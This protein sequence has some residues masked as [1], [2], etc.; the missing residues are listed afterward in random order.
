MIHL[1]GDYIHQVEI[2]SFVTI[3]KDG[4]C[5]QGDEPARFPDLFHYEMHIPWILVFKKPTPI[6]FLFG[7]QPVQGWLNARVIRD[8]LM[9]KVFQHS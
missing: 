4:Q 1:L 8:L 7:S 9:G 3:P 6:T 5:F 2:S